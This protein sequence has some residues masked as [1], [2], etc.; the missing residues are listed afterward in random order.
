[1]KLSFFFFL[2]MGIFTTEG[3]QRVF[4]AA[5]DIEIEMHMMDWFR[6]SNQRLKRSVH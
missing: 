3:V 6:Q 1:M 4:K 2:I 5:T